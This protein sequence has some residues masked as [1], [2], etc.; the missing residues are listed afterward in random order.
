[1]EHTEVVLYNPKESY[2]L[3]LT[4]QRT[5]H[6]LWTNPVLQNEVQWLVEWAVGL[7]REISMEARI[8][9]PPHCRPE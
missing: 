9:I 6:L 8:P 7:I 1:M 4:W 5:Q 3:F 2:T